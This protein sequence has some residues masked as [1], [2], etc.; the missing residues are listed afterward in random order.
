MVSVF[1]R[2]FWMMIGPLTLGISLYYIVTSGTGWRTTADICFF[3]ILGG[4]ILGRWLEFRG[5]NP[6]TSTGEVATPA[7]LRHYI[8][9]LVIGGP[10]A[11]V[12]ANLIG[13]HWL[14][15]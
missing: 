5:G 10:I 9:G 3:L 11:W 1:G 15:Q 2:L 4:M 12:I 6:Q 13:N 14:A 7:D 8:L